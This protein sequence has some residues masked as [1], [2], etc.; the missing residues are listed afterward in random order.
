MRIVILVA[1][2]SL[3]VVL[4]ADVRADDGDE[5]SSPTSLGLATPSPR[6]GHYVALGLHLASATVDDRDRGRRGPAV[7]QGI[8]LRLGERLTPRI[9]V[10]IAFAYARIGGDE[11]WSF[12]RLTVH[13]QLYTSERWFVHGGFGFGAAGGSDPEDPGFERGSYGD[14][15][16]MG[17]GRNFYLTSSNVSGGWIATPVVSAEYSRDSVFP[18]SAIMLG[19]ELSRW[20]GVSRDQLALEAEK[21]Y[22]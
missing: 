6:Q 9:D 7:G 21:A 11:S 5:A 1:V 18:N 15:Y 3:S 10:G 22:E 13:G 4:A 20:W 17:V 2:S 12:G 14:V 16:T 8:T 19:V